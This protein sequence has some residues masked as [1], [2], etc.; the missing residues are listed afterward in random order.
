VNTG[1]NL[2]YLLLGAMLGA[3]AVS[4]WV[5]EHTLRNLHV[6]RTTPG[7]VPVERDFRLRYRV[8][9]RKRWLPSLAV[10]LKEP[11]LPGLAFIP[12]VAAG[13]TVHTHATDRFVRRGVYPL[14]ELTLATEFPFGLFRKEREVA[15]P[16]E[17][18]VWPRTDR[19]VRE[20]LVGAGNDRST[21]S[22]STHPATGPRGEFRSLREYRP[23]DDA[24]D[25]HWRT[26]AR[27]RQP[28]IR[29]YEREA[30]EATWIV[31][32]VGDPPGDEAEAAVEVAASL[33]ARAARWGQPFA[34]FAGSR[35]VGPG[36]GEAHLER[37]LDVLARVDFGGE[38]T[39]YPHE[40]RDRAVLVTPGRIL[41]GFPQV[42][43]TATAGVREEMP[44]RHSPRGPGGGPA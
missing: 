34:L 42:I 33:C 11:G 43:R 16:G 17:L 15:L 20:D 2:L 25:I 40:S 9:N 13:E 29:E 19:V 37:A 8:T 1:N 7:G 44:E 18:V 27:L 30:A 21:P 4:G 26:S 41:P 14:E 24:R 22:A 39:S 6:V 5:S 32:E 28:V 12:R 35:A 3:V 36:T 10:E 38:A 31:L 23:G